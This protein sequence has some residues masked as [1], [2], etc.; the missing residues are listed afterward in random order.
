[1]ARPD[2]ISRLAEAIADGS[3]VDWMTAES[4]AQ[5]EW[6][7]AVVRR[8]RRI[9][10]IADR[11]RRSEAPD[12]PLSDV[13][14]TR[15]T[16]ETTSLRSWGHLQILDRLGEGAFGEVYRAF[17]TKL[18]REVALKLLRERESNASSR[19]SAVIDE[20]RLLARVR[21]PNVVTV[22]GADRM[23][24]RVGLW[25]DLIR[26]RTLEQ[27]V[28]EH[29]PL[30]PQEA[31]L[32]GIDLCH[33]LAAVHQAG[34]LHRDVKAQ[35]VMREDGG[36][37]VLMDFGTGREHTDRSTASV[38]HLTGTPLY[39]APEVFRGESASVRSDLYSLGVLLYYLV[40]G[41]HPIEA[42]TLR[43]VDD[44]HRRSQRVHLSDRRP[45]L[46]A[47]FVQVVERA[48]SVDPDRRYSTAGAM[49][50]AL[51]EALERAPA[52]ASG[53]FRQRLAIAITAL[54]LVG[55]AAGALWWRFGN[56]PAVLPFEKRDWI[57]IAAFDNRTGEKELDGVVEA[58]LQHELVNSRFVNVV[59]GARV[60]DTLNLMKR[61]PD[62]RVDASL[63]REVAQRDGHIRAYLAGTVEKLGSTY[64]IRA[65]LFDATDG[66]VVA[67]VNEEAAP[68]SSSATPGFAAV[69]LPGALRRISNRVRQN[70]GERWADIRHSNQELEKVVTPSL[71]ALRLYSDSYKLGGLGRWPEALPVIRRA[72]EIDP[73]FASAQIWLAWCLNNTNA[74]PEEMW[75]VAKRAMDLAPG[76]AD[77]ERHWI[78]GS[79]LL[80]LTRKNKAGESAIP[81]EKRKDAI[82]AYKVL[83][84][85][86][87]DHRWAVGNL[88]ALLGPEGT[89]EA[90]P[91][92]LR[93]AEARPNNLALAN[94]ALHALKEGG[95][96]E[97]SL[98]Q[99]DRVIALARASGVPPEPQ[100]VLTPS[101]AAWMR[102]DPHGAIRELDSLMTGLP[103]T[104]NQYRLPD[105]TNPYPLVFG[106][107]RS[108]L[109][110]G[111]VDSARRAAEAVSVAR[112]REYLLA[113]T[114]F[115]NDDRNSLREHLMRINY[116]AEDPF[117][118]NWDTR[119]RIAAD[120]MAVFLLEA[121][122]SRD[123]ESVLHTLERTA[124]YRADVARINI[125]KGRIRHVR[126]DIAG[127]LALMPAMPHVFWGY[128]LEYLSEA[129][130][131][132]GNVEGAIKALERNAQIKWQ[133]RPGW[134]RN[135]LSL[136][137]LYH[138]ANQHDRER[139][140]TT[141]LS[142]LL[143]AADPTFPALVRLRDLQRQHR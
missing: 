77:W 126:G 59:S 128:E 61:P 93:A 84:D 42:R 119:D 129:L 114:A 87:P 18:A 102:A 122:L 11:Q 17:D 19:V 130:V 131:A 76:A 97:Q 99:A 95:D 41:T 53:W 67:I 29:G 121:G 27:V 51:S 82:A 124:Q 104:T 36:R 64:L 65:S 112:E 6:E 56:S 38:D 30:G 139:V 23:D 49:A 100:A 4:T 125:L 140:V 20:G 25:M 103:A 57:L 143:A 116:A 80:L 40:T 63:A 106:I 123:A 10:E 16:D 111:K 52:R 94:L 89:R 86:L 21:H 90:L 3:P 2:A 28:R 132:S 83:V 134:L 46:P 135:Q 127:A 5:S 45:D 78:Q 72:I 47:K 92:V 60:T 12:S 32:I 8:L 101:W 81:S 117:A 7:R 62:T 66:Q 110:L 44:A 54:V 13:S 133:V 68:S 50:M 113:S 98:S 142:E 118:G 96:V 15:T 48:I 58:A 107:V 108:Y 24:G 85:L 71:E 115:Y 26:G 69:D 43:E 109:T 75:V 70:V 74:P 88:R 35:N 91:Y 34:L 33:A 39:L 55:A 137:R 14:L 31:A 138:V 120:L 1:M 79:A 105:T 9:G 37:V 141:E 136:A 73:N 22:H